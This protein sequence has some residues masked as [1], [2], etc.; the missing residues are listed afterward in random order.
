MKNC[1]VIYT[2]TQACYLA[3]FCFLI[4]EPKCSQSVRLQDYLK[5]DISRKKWGIKFAF[6]MA[7]HAQ[8]TQT[9]KFAKSLQCLKK[10]MSNKLIFCAD[11]HVSFLQVDAIICGWCDE[12]C[13][14]YTK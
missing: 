5:Y 11:K 7:S 8:R 1:I 9:N 12:A 10:N 14:K 3:K 4:Y 13:L 2:S 6:F